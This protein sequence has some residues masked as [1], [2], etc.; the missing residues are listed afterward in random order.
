[1]KDAKKLSIYILTY[2]NEETI[3]RALASA[4]WA[5]EI[6][7]V[8]HFSVD[9]TVDI[10]KKYTDRI[11]Q[12]EWTN[13]RDEYNYAISLTTYDWVM[14]L[15]SDEEISRELAEEIRRELAD[16]D[17]RWAGYLVPRLNFYMGKWIKHG[18]WYPEYKLRI[19]NKKLG[20]WAG[21]SFDPYVVLAGKAKKL[22][23]PCFHYSFKNLSHHAQKLNLYSS[24]FAQAKLE[25]DPFY[26]ANFIHL[27]LRPLFRF[28][29]NYI[30]KAGFLDGMPGLVACV[31]ASYY[32]F[33]KYAK[34]WEIQHQK[35]KVTHE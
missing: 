27:F 33:L 18:G 1:M 6:V 22:R 15:D 5:D 17:G 21:K 23:Y 31:M 25:Q 2:N 14:F 34:I 29:R 35:Q 26:K 7:V 16:N 8:D 19:F 20:R 28:F 9:A 12:K 32:V 4:K 10:C 3:E 24:L 11:Y 30:L 13:H